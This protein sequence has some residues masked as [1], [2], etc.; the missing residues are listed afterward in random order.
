MVEESMDG[1]IVFCFALLFHLLA[2]LFFKFAANFALQLCTLA[3]R[4]TQ[5]HHPLPTLASPAIS[6]LDGICSGSQSFTNLNPNPTHHISYLTNRRRNTKNISLRLRPYPPHSHS[7]ND[8]MHS[9]HIGSTLS[10][11][12]GRPAADG[13]FF[14]P[15]SAFCEMA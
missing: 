8:A 10:T 13:P 4:S 1:R 7:F 14:L 12:H 9:H 3:Q 2:T 5:H 11:R 6:T 15:L